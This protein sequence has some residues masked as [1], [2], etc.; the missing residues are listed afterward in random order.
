MGV[1]VNHQ[2]VRSHQPTNERPSDVHSYVNHSLV[3]R[4]SKNTWKGARKSA[5]TI[6]TLQKCLLPLRIEIETP[7][8]PKPENASHCSWPQPTDCQLSFLPIEPN[9]ILLGSLWS[10]T[11]WHIPTSALR[12]CIVLLFLDAGLHLL[13]STPSVALRLFMHSLVYSIPE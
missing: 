13:C 7:T 9:S 12:K 11:D 10:L 8:T 1:A 4:M 6:H 3:F 5:F 2:V